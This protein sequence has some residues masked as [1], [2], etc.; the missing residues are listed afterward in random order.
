MDDRRDIPTKFDG[1]TVRICSHELVPIVT[2]APSPVRVKTMTWA[3]RTEDP[4]GKTSLE[5]LAAAAHSF[6][7]SK[8]CERP[9]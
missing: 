4:G 8:G 2:R 3:A 7:F 9:R 5:E 6:C 1:F